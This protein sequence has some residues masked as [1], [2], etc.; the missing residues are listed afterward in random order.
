MNT[1]FPARFQPFHN[2]HLYVIERSLQMID[3]PLI[4]GVVVAAPSTHDSVT[5]FQAQAKEHHDP[6]RNPFTLTERLTMLQTLLDQELS[7]IR[8]NIIVVS[9][10][11]PEV[12][13]ELVTSMFPSPRCW[14]V[15]KC[16]EVFDDLKA[17]FFEEMGDEVMRVHFEARV[18][19][20][21]IRKRLHMAE[22]NLANWVPESIAGYI[23]EWA[24]RAKL[25]MG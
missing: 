15:P 12:Y 19:G 5:E 14:I 11:Q 16:G 20:Y 24:R 2:D 25:P 23:S 8:D 7:A 6:I 22:V 3:P 10:P 1:I 21:E 17:Q 9:L 4:L 13:W 18:T